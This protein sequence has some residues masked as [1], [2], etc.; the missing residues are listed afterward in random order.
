MICF[1]AWAPRLKLGRRK[2]QNFSLHHLGGP[3]RRDCPNQPQ[4]TPPLEPVTQD[5]LNSQMHRLRTP[6][7]IDTPS[8]RLSRTNDKETSHQL[9]PEVDRS[10]SFQGPT[11]KEVRLDKWKLK[12]DGS[13]RGMAVESILFRVD[14]FQE[15]YGLNGQQ[16]FREFHILLTGAAT[17]WN[18]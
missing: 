13:D 2:W 17:E 10:P 6:R 11:P 3:G 12:F 15:M 7:R 18:W 8:H 9:Q 16:V 14:Q 1:W 4:E 5:M